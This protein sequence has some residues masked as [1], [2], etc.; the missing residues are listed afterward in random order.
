[1]PPLI[2]K[3][4]KWLH[5]K[6]VL[7][8]SK[9]KLYMYNEWRKMTMQAWYWVEENDYALVCLWYGSFSSHAYNLELLLP[10]HL[11][12]MP[13][14]TVLLSASLFPSL[15]HMT[16]IPLS[17]ILKLISV[18]KSIC[19]EESRRYCTSSSRLRHPSVC[20]VMLQQWIGDRVEYE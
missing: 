2:T 5:Y 18:S 12:T 19:I 6:P 1:M 4:G 16:R 9:C 8:E 10:Q 3:E 15:C 17:R 20:A 13:S 7:N 11:H 14:H